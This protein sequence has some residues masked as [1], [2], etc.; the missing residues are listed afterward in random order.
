MVTTE[1]LI[2]LNRAIMHE[3]TENK[4]ILYIQKLE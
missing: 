2:S 3:L 4:I 1:I